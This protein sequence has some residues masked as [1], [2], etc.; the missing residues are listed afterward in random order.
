LVEPRNEGQLV[1]AMLDLLKNKSFDP[2]DLR[3][4]ALKHF[5][6]A[7]IAKQLDEVYRKVASA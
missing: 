1:Q 3:A 2:Q 6:Y 4:Y 7:A 5:S